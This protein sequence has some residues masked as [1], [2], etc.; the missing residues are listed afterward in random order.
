MH[1]NHNAREALHL[2]KIITINNYL[3]IHYLSSIRSIPLWFNLKA[4]LV[5]SVY[6][7]YII[8]SYN[9]NLSS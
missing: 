8:P 3:A 7:L 1:G 2:L 4:T 6:V 5:Y 9:K